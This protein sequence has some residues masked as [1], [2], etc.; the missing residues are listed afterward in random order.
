MTPVLFHNWAVLEDP[1]TFAPLLAACGHRTRGISRVMWAYGCE[2][3]ITPGSF[4]GVD[5][6]FVIPDIVLHFEDAY[7]PGLV[8]F[9][10]KRPGVRPVQKDADKLNAYTRLNSMRG[11]ERKTGCFL[12]GVSMVEE[13]RRLSRNGP[14][15]SW[16]QLQDLQRAAFMHEAPVALPWLERTYALHGFGD[17][18]APDPVVGNQLGTHDARMAITALNVSDRQK[19]FLLGSETV[20]ACLCGHTVSPPLDWLAMEPS[21]EQLSIRRFQTTQARRLCRWTT[22]W[23]PRQEH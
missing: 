1:E 12:V 20:E 7:G 4:P 19:R 18:P 17:A 2:E 22:E 10:V 9:E 13:A 14:V 21:R 15:I 8:A 23:N 11:I 6:R 5:G 16:D 3:A